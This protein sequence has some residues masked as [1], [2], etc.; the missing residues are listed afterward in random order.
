[1]DSYSASP[2][3][4]H[5]HGPGW[6]YPPPPAPPPRVLPKD[7]YTPWANRLLA[8]DGL[9]DRRAIVALIAIILLAAYF[10]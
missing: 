7:A 8:C 1:M 2:P 4:V 3:P 5:P 6:G 9:T 10:F